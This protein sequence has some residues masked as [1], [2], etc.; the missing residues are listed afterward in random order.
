MK[1]DEFIGNLEYLREGY[2]DI[3]VVWHEKK[4]GEYYPKIRSLDIKKQENED[5]I[6]I[7]NGY[8]ETDGIVESLYGS[9]YKN[10]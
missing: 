7:L 6:L 5:Y 3:D 2:G 9:E 1:L 10:E 4:F 8:T